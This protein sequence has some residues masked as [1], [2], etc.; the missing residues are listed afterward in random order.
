[1]NYLL[2]TLVVFICT[3]DGYIRLRALFALILILFLFLINIKHINKLIITKKH[4]VFSFVISIFFIIYTSFALINPQF[5]LQ[6]PYDREVFVFKVF[7][8][9]S[10]LLLF[11]FIP[12][13]F[14][15]ND[16]YLNC[17]RDVTYLHVSIFL[18]QFILFYIF[19]FKLDITSIFGV[20]QRT[21]LGLEGVNIFRA[22]GLYVEPSNYAAFV[23][24]IFFPYVYLKRKL[25]YWD[26]IPPLT[27]FLTFSTAGFFSGILYLIGYAIKNKIFKNFRGLVVFILGFSVVVGAIIVN[28]NRFS[29]EDGTSSNMRIDLLNY[30][31]QTRV[32]DLN[33]FFLGSGIYSYDYDIYLREVSSLGRDIASIQDFTMFLYGFITL[34]IMGIFLLLYLVFKTKGISGKIFLLSILISKMTYLYPIFIFVVIYILY[35]DGRK[36]L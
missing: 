36:K 31:I 30:V 10:L 9:L 27:M 35:G 4:L 12:F 1:M 24:T 29:T 18:I 22:S 16:K 15:S 28:L 8:R 34:G 14:F 21:N 23:A 6:I 13:I 2:C 5:Y 17:F 32:E 3:L 19:S 7:D 25:T 11:F 33:L 20:E 26:L